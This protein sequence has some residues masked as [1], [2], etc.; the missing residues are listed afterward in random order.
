MCSHV[1]WQSQWTMLGHWLYLSGGLNGGCVLS[2]MIMCF[3]GEQ[4]GLVR[5]RKT[6]SGTSEVELTSKTKTSEACMLYVGSIIHDFSIHKLRSDAGLIDLLS[7]LLVLYGTVQFNLLWS[8]DTVWHHRTWSAL[9][10]EM[11]NHLW[12]P[13]HSTEDNL[14]GNSKDVQYEMCSKY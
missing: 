11:T 5:L 9:V 12:S 1:G 7:S 14:T 6:C 4:I 10:Q 13:W 8:S 2:S 3:V